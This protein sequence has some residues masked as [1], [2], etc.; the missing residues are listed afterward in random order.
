M[1]EIEPSTT[2][3]QQAPLLIKVIF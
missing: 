3:P 1:T 2:T